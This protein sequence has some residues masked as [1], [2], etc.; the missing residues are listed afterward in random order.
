MSHEQEA[1]LRPSGGVFLAG[2]LMGAAVGAG[3]ALLFAPKAGRELRRDLAESARRA[4]ESARDAYR[5]A[6]ERVGKVGETATKAAG[7]VRQA[8][9]EVVGGS[10]AAES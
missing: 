6:T 1:V 4:R 9:R 3:L 5:R 10:R 7:E 2:L 8:L